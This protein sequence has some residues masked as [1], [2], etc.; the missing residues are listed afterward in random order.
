MPATSQSKRMCAPMR[1]ASSMRPRVRADRAIASLPARSPWRS[2]MVRAPH[3][4]IHNTAKDAWASRSRQACGFGCTWL[5]LGFLFCDDCG[6]APG[7]CCLP[8]CPMRSKAS[9]H[10]S[11]RFCP[12]PLG[13]GPPA[14]ARRSLTAAFSFHGCSARPCAGCGTV[15]HLVAAQ[16]AVLQTGDFGTPKTGGAERASRGHISAARAFQPG[17]RGGIS[18]F[19][20]STRQRQS[21]DRNSASLRCS[22]VE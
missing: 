7:A 3:G 4:R 19:Q 1:H 11:P 12:C 9:C 18:P 13:R 15:Q 20:R 22:V 8:L 16:D 5:L 2:C 10:Y 17:W 6:V 21:S 14:R